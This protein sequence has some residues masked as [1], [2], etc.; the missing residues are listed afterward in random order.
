ME[1]KLNSFKE[2]T[3]FVSKKKSKNETTKPITKTRV[4]TLLPI[5]FKDSIFYY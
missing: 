3:K 1:I 2:V 4:N 5:L